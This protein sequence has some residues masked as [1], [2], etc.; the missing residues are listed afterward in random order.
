MITNTPFSQTNPTP[1]SPRNSPSISGEITNLNTELGNFEGSAIDGYIRES[2]AVTSLS[3]NSFSVSGNVTAY[4]SAGRLLRANSATTPIYLTVTSSAYSTNTTVTTQQTTV[5]S[6][7]NTIDLAIQ[8]VGGT[9]PTLYSRTLV[10]PTIT[11]PTVTTG[12]FTSPALT[13]PT[14][15]NPTVTTGTFVKPVLNGVQVVTTNTYSATPTL[16]MSTSN[17]QVMTLTGNATLAVSNVSTGQ[18]FSLELIQDATGSRTVT[19]WAGITWT[20]STVPTL[21]TTAAKKDTFVFRCTGTSTYDGY[22]VGQNVG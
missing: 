1:T 10:T 6:P 19:W 17:V 9:N 4:Y 7:L 11:N 5:P 12:T 8:P 13:T 3:N 16:D 2:A 22:I 18:Y 15:T 14:V 21:T 20:D